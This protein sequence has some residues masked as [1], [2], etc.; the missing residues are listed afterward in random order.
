MKLSLKSFAILSAL[1]ITPV[2]VGAGS[3]SAQPVRFDGSYVGAGVNAGLTN[4]G[5]TGDAATFGGNVQGRFAIPNTPVSVRG[6]VA[7]NGENSAVIP[8]LSYD[9]PIAKN[10]NVYAG[11]GYSFVQKD[12]KATQVGNKDAAVLQ[13]G[14]ES[15]VAR[16]VVLYTDAKYGINAYQGSGSGSLSLQT[17]VGIKF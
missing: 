2:V 10:T 9:L 11:A 14:V 13:L 15:E 1:V 4:G 16:G 5:R 17:G 8:S 12:G 6:T 3:V 7:F